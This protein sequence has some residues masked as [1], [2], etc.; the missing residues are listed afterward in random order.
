MYSKAFFLL[1]P[2]C[3]GTEERELEGQE[4]KS[5]AKACITVRHDLRVDRAKVAPHP[6]WGSREHPELHTHRNLRQSG[7]G[8]EA[9]EL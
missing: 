6:D 1:P 9:N 4:A 8:K 7:K 2:A 5:K 3:K